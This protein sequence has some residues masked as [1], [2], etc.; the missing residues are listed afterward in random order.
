MEHA[1]S[2]CNQVN[3]FFSMKTS[4]PFDETCVENI[5]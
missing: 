4:N 3:V 2:V 1:K 5:K